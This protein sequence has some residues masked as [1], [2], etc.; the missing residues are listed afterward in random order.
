MEKSAYDQLRQKVVS[1][2]NMNI[3]IISG[4]GSLNNHEAIA[5]ALQFKIMK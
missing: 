2:N 5:R 4:E 3:T 1:M